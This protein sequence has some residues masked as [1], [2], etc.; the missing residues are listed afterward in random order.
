M[1]NISRIDVLNSFLHKLVYKIVL[2]WGK[3]FVKPNKKMLV[4]ESFPD[5][6]DNSRAFSDYLLKKGGYKIYWIVKDAKTYAKRFPN[7]RIHFLQ[8]VDRNGVASIRTLLVLLRAGWI[9]STHGFTYVPGTHKRKKFIKLWHGCSFKDKTSQA[10]F[11]HFDFALVSGPSFIKTKSY[12]WGCPESKIIAKGYPRYDWLITKSK[13]AESVVN[14]WKRDNKKL[15]VWMPTFRNDKY[16]LH[17]ESA[18]I[19]QFP[20]MESATQWNELDLLCKKHS[21]LL[22]IKLH[23]FQKDY[24]IDY[25]HLNNIKMITNDDFD[26]NNIQLYEFLGYSDALITD[27][28]SIGVDYLIVDNPIAYTLDDYEVYRKTR[29]FVFEDPRQYMPGYHLYSFCDLGK[30][31]ADIA[32]NKD[33]FREKRNSVKKQLVYES[34]NYCQDIAKEL[35]L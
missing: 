11:T 29:G 18:V 4:F 27:Y 12:F 3:Y 30:F 9:F 14:L 23:P 34:E 1:N 15:I 16:N 17:N 22:V 13:K 21:V 24:Q 19:T 6:S 7:P 26:A 33:E 28:S 32:D 25:S 10:T 2:D 8:E 31:I 35:N 20:L 5:Y